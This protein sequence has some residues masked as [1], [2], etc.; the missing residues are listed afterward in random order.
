MSHAHDT[1]PRPISAN[2]A[3]T[4]CDELHPTIWRALAYSECH[5]VSKVFFFYKEKRRST[6]RI[7]LPFGFRF[8]TFFFIHDINDW[9]RIFNRSVGKF[10][11]GNTTTNFY[12]IK[13]VMGERSNKSMA[14]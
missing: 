14:F 6:N 2:R 11:V 9:E 5:K 1:G 4:E 7:F 12:G 10:P 3:R 13:D 8:F